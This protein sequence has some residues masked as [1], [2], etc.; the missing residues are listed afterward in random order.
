MIKNLITAITICLL[1]FGVIFVASVATDPNFSS[2][3]RDGGAFA[4]CGQRIV[5]GA[6]LYRDCWDNKPPA[7]YYLNAVI[8]ALGSQKQWNMWLFQA[9]WLSLTTLVFYEVLKNIW[10]R[11]SALIC[12]TLMLLTLLYPLY[13][14]GG[15]LTETYALLPI[16]LALGAVGGYLRTGKRI[17]LIG[18]GLFSAISFLFKPTYISVG[19]AAIVILTFIRLHQRRYLRLTGETGLILAS[20]VLPLLLVAAFWIAHNDLYD[21]LYA[22]FIHNRLYIE[23][24]FSLKAFIAT[25]RILIVEQ[26]LAAVFGLAVISIIVYIFDNWK[27]FWRIGTEKLE[28]RKPESNRFWMMAGLIIVVVLDILFT[29]LPGTNFRHYYQIPIL[30]MSA[31]SGYLFDHLV[32]LKPVFKKFNPYNILTLSATV[33][34][35]LPWLVEV[36]G[37]E[38]PSLANWKELRSNPNIT[39]Y[40]PDAMEKFILENSTPEQ[41]IL[42]WDYDPIIYFHVDRR[43][44]TRFIFLR[45]IYTPIPRAAN[46]FAEFQQELQGDPPILIITSKTAQQGLPYLGLSEADICSDCT[47]EIRQGVIAFKRYVEQYYQPYTDIQTWAIYKRIK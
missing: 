41:S 12:T 31:I 21:L 26:P 10:T 22:V 42:V 34:I 32:N 46:G 9:A 37:K 29:T 2:M 11:K 14:S 15:N 1:A 44:P 17:F 28:L 13:F 8:I 6:L 45:H 23:E 7:I 25:F 3:S 18:I 27:K 16:T 35:L 38:A 5:E 19:I 36:I 47:S 33:V 4:Y 43:S 24:G 20:F 40:Q 39:V 30:S